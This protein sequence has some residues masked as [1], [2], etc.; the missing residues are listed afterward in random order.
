MS[1]LKTGSYKH[2]VCLQF[3]VY[4]VHGWFFKHETF[5]FDQIEVSKMIVFKIKQTLKEFK[6]I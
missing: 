4:N 2:L 5:I 6:D 1:K 3:T